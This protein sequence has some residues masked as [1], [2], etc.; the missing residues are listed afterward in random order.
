MGEFVLITTVIPTY[1]RSASLQRAIKSALS[2]TAPGVEVHVYDD[3][4]TDDTQEVV[5]AVASADNRLHYHRNASNLGYSSNVACGVTRVRS[6]FFSILADDD[7]LLPEFYS[8][9]LAALEKHPA[10]QWVAGRVPRRTGAG[11][12]VMSTTTTL[13]PGY[14][15]PPKSFYAMNRRGHPNWAGV[16][17][18]RDVLDRV[19]GL[20]PNRR[21]I[22]FDF[23]LRS[24]ALAYVILAQ[25]VA[26]FTQH[27]GSISS[28]GG[29]KERLELA[30]PSVLHSIDDF[31]ANPSLSGSIP[32]AG[33]ALRTVTM[34]SLLATGMEAA[35]V[36]N[37]DVVSRIIRIIS[38]DMRQP[39][40]G[41]LCAGM[42]STPLVPWI[43][44][45]LLATRRHFTRG[46]LREALDVGDLPY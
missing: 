31:V 27:A 36:G 38:T 14:Y 42:L 5:A 1:N 15:R 29:L 40:V 17:F 22:D 25:P 43:A 35:H 37:Y 44:S 39:L 28:G 26:I 12:P 46:R 4:S 30:F 13:R 11:A 20:N 45:L 33:L 18:R 24:S 9:G 2:Q 16:L 19:G 41:A 6:P 8:L 23:Q 7:I 3:C 34:I 10:A 21:A 32:G